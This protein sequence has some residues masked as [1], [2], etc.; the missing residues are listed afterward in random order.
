M[1]TL[2]CGDK[3]F[4]V[5]YLLIAVL[6]VFFSC[7]GPAIMVETVVGIMNGGTISGLIINNTMVNVFYMLSFASSTANPVIYFIFSQCVSLLI[8]LEIYTYTDYFHAKYILNYIIII[9]LFFVSYNRPIRACYKRFF[10]CY[11][12]RNILLV[13]SGEV[14]T[15]KGNFSRSFNLRTQGS[16]LDSKYS[17][18]GDMESSTVED[19]SL[20]TST[21]TR[22]NQS[23]SA[24]T[25]VI[26]SSN[27]EIQCSPDKRFC[28]RAG[29]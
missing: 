11:A 23:K 15:H 29:Q 3:L 7:W 16:V 28:W 24:T 20:H 14:A 18:S 4:Q 12:F 9:I 10:F 27:I 6:V 22:L 17:S 25:D 13:P 26:H 21:H 5:I 8:T 19:T 2:I 1:L